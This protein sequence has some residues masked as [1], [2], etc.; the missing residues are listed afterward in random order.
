MVTKNVVRNVYDVVN[1]LYQQQVKHAAE[2]GKIVRLLFDIQRDK[3]SGR[4]RISLSDNIIK[5]GFPEIERVN[6]LS[7]QLLVNYYSNCEMT[8]LKGM[9]IVLDS[10]PEAIEAR[11]RRGGT[12]TN[13]TAPI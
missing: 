6:Y 3:S 11:R 8:Y 10:S 13:P 2:C 9:K 12:I 1:Q 4:Y 7:R 5:K